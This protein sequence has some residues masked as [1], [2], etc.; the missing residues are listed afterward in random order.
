MLVTVLVSFEPSRGASSVVGPGCA[1]RMVGVEYVRIWEL[2]TGGSGKGR[3][4]EAYAGARFGKDQ[5]T[6]P[7]GNIFVQNPPPPAIRCHASC[8]A[9]KPNML[10]YIKSTETHVRTLILVGNPFVRLNVGLE[11]SSVVD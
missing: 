3:Q 6:G 11:G 2:E 1:G 7:V 4:V 9:E 10:R 8:D 5:T